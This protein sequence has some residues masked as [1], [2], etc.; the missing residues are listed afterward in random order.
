MSESPNRTR[1]VLVDDHPMVR[2]RLAEVINREDD[3]VVCGEAEDRGS[4]LDVIGR[5]LPDL[6]IVDLTLKRSNGLDLIKDLHVMHPKLLLLVLSMQDETLYAERV[7]RAG[8]HGY[9]TKQEA[10]R[11]IL[12]AI[13][14]VLG[15]KVFLSPE[16]SADILSR[17]LGKSK[18]AI[19]SLEVLSDREL[20]V[21]DL[22]GQ[23][24]GTRQIAEQLGLDV[25]TVETYR[26]RIKEKLEIR[27]ASELLRKAIAWK[28]DH[29]NE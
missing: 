12:N 4:A 5:E 6:A 17:M 16:I 22:V 29:P 8:A 15:G 28:H 18:G 10:T 1:I 20:Q 26:S 13:R 27:D 21:F 9:I 24:F 14:E 7:I 25:K 3:M 23:G 11:K 19:R 2:E